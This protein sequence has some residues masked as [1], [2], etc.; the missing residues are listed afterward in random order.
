MK[1]LL[2]PIIP[3]FALGLLIA[4]VTLAAVADA[5]K[6]QDLMTPEEFKA[7]GLDKLSP[8]ELGA[9]NAWLLRFTAH[10]APVVRQTSPE[11]KREV[12][13]SKPM[14][15]RS[16]ING[17]FDGWSGKTLFRLKNGQV[18]KQRLSGTYRVHLVDPE[19][20]IEQRMLGFYWMKILATGRSVGVTPVN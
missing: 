10:E 18:W 19:V 20:E 13:E 9:L 6:V 12:A 17:E 4:W 5:P 3:R 2:P 11:V 15:I 1:R 8:A 7:S 14:V 16:K